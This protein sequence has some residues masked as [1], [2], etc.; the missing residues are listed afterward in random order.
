MSSTTGS[1]ELTLTYEELYHRL[2]ADVKTHEVDLDRINLCSVLTSLNVE[3]A[4]TVCILIVLYAQ[5]EGIDVHKLPY[6][7]IVVD[8]PN[9]KGAKYMLKNLP[10]EL[11]CMIQIFISMIVNNGS[12]STNPHH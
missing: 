5:K 12:S 4:T 8:K 9:G 11:I 7:G 6:S 3:Q 1:T 2:K 10:N